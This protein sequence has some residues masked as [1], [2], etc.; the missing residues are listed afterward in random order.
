MVVNFILF[1]ACWFALVLGAA[2]GLIW[3]GLV[4]TAG[5]L[6]WELARE[7]V[8]GRLLALCG[9]ALAC[10][11]LIDGGFV[12]LDLIRYASPAGP[13]VP[14]WILAL[15]IAF[16]LALRRSLAWLEGRYGLAALFGAVGAPLSYAAGA[17]LEAAAF[18]PGPITLLG[19]SLTWLLATPLLV[20]FAHAAPLPWRLAPSDETA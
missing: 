18:P 17:R 14:L 16:A 8:R 13:L 7:P 10:G 20:W 9:L 3:P 12:A 4:L 15:W 1:N 11:F 6:A 2:N 5:F 19:M